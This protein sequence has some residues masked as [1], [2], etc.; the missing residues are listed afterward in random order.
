MRLLRKFYERDTAEVA[1]QLLGLELVHDTCEGIA[2]GKIVE[3][4]AYYGEDDPASRATKK[5]TKI[6]EI[7]WGR[8]GFTLVYMVHANW[9]FNVTTE[10]EGTPGAVLIRALEPLRGISI[11]RGR[12]GRGDLSDLT[13]GPGKL[14]QA[15]DITKEHHGLDLTSSEEVYI[16]EREEQGGFSIRTSPRIGV[17]ED[18][19]REL[20]F[21]IEGNEFLS[22]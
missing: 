8:P 9:L 10:G 22:R 5:R 21:Y 11:M 6:N 7:M 16:R 13:S 20:R 19:D 4:E 12:R 2:S 14:T 15:L 1:R 18:L 17:S 3:T